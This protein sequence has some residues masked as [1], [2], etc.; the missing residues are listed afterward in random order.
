MSMLADINTKLPAHDAKL[1]KLASQPTILTDEDRVAGGGGVGTA[2]EKT[3]QTHQTH[4]GKAVHSWQHS[5]HRQT[6]PGH[7]R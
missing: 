2:Q 3:Y 6:S 1:T 7:M 4:H 5:G